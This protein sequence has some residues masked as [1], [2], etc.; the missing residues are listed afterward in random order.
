MLEIH[1]Q[2]FKYATSRYGTF[3]QQDI[4]C[5]GFSHE[6]MPLSHHQT[7]PAKGMMLD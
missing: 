4:V 3:R 5:H 2:L 6:S 7:V 1:F